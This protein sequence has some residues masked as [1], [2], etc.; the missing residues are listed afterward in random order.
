MLVA[1]YFRRLAANVQVKAFVDGVTAAATGAIAGAVVVLGR[2]ALIDLPTLLI[3]IVT[4]ALT[5][6]AKVPEPLVILA[7]GAGGFALKGA[8][9]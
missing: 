6:R 1:P 7:A 2:R 3:C 9:P 4:L 5:L 8:I